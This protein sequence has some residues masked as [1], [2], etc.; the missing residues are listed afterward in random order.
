MSRCVNG[1]CLVI[2]LWSAALLPCRLLFW[3]I[4]FDW[5]LKGT[6]R[7]HRSSVDNKGP[8]GKG[9]CNNFRV[10][11]WFIDKVDPFSFS[12]RFWFLFLY[13]VV[14]G[15]VASVAKE[16][17]VAVRFEVCKGSVYVH[18]TCIPPQHCVVSTWWITIRYTI[19][20]P[21][22]VGLKIVPFLK[23][24]KNPTQ[25]RLYPIDPSVCS[26]QLQGR[27][28]ITYCVGY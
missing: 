15:I 10:S 5:T 9:I 19:F 28:K 24:G 25:R 23:P 8:S 1:E 2:R 4:L 3:D 16:R 6:S 11:S 20:T 7:L 12:P 22:S 27:L 26:T 13:C 17:G 21:Q 18:V 14:L